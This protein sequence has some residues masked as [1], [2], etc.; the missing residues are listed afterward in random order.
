MAGSFRPRLHA[1]ALTLLLDAP[2][3]GGAQTPASVEA[4]TP[5]TLDEA[6]KRALD[7][8]LDIAVER[9]NPQTFDLSLAGLRAT[10]RP[11]LLASIGERSQLNASPT[12]R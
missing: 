10:Y 8:N 12:T 2:M 3:T 7:R 1:L 6:V 11:L 9:L 5:L 4:P